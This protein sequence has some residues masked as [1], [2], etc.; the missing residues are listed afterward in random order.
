MAD[1]PQ[2]TQL[3]GAWISGTSAFN[4]YENNLEEI[5]A[6]KPDMGRL[7]SILPD[8]YHVYYPAPLTVACASERDEF[9][10]DAHAC[11][12]CAE[13]DFCP[14][15]RGVGF[16]VWTKIALH[17]ICTSLSSAATEER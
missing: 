17:S 6:L 3:D 16:F 14:A 8:C 9:P 12:E 1:P 15:A 7:R 10:S 11:A 4:L 2:P 13:Y 5:P